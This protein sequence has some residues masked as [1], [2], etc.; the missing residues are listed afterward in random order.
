MF[1]NMTFENIME[2]SLA[3]VTTDVDKRQGSVIYDA[4]APACAELAQL[5]IEL[6]NI[7][8]EGFADTADREYLILRA[9][10]RGL[11]PNEATSA[12]LRGVFDGEVP[13]GSR[14]NLGELNYEVSEK[15]KN[16]E[17]KLVCETTGTQGNKYFGTLT[18]IDYIQGITS[19]AI[20][21]LLIPGTD[22]EDTEVFRQRYFDSVKN[23]AF[24]GNVAD[25]KRL[26]KTISG[27]GQVKI[28]RVWNGGGTVKVIMTDTENNIPTDE[29]LKEVKETLDPSESE[30]CGMGLVPVGHSVTVTAP[31]VRYVDVR[32]DVHLENKTINDIK[33]EVLEVVEDFMKELNED[34]EEGDIIIYA[35][36]IH[37]RLMEIEGIKNISGLTVNEETHLILKSNELAGVKNVYIGKEDWIGV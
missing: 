29:L 28:E 32:F 26:L 25:Y 9:K 18:P 10:E 11:T 8:K 30:G 17:Y 27:V 5:Y 6:E 24:G 37:T 33:L 22:D 21:E 20:T 36:D 3:A 1:E 14:F 15:I 35:S 34:W 13:I 12:V 16:Y 7:L 2:K 23:T 31:T 19:A 4:L